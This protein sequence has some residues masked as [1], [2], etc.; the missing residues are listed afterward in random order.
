[1]VGKS[2][3]RDFVKRRETS[4]IN[5]SVHPTCGNTGAE[6]RR[7]EKAAVN[8]RIVDLCSGQEG[9]VLKLKG[10]G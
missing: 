6:E 9:T 7:G 4:K 8:T 10:N 3:L 2:W 1:M 5:S